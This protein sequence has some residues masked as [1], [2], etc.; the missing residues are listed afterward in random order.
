MAGWKFIVLWLENELVEMMVLEMYG[1]GV[2][3][4]LSFI[5]ALLREICL[6]SLQWRGVAEDAVEK[7]D[8]GSLPLLMGPCKFRYWLSLLRRETVAR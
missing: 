2:G 6:G 4:L 1:D 7:I 3:T 8:R 5:V